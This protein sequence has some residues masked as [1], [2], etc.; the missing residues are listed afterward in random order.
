[1]TIATKGFLPVLKRLNAVILPPSTQAFGCN[2]S[3]KKASYVLKSGGWDHLFCDSEREEQ[4]P[5]PARGSMA[6][7][8]WLTALVVMDIITFLLLL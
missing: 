5:C 1:M 4:E 3:R 7:T 2:E 8:E 6:R